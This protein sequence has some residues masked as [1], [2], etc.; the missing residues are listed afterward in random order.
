MSLHD[1]SQGFPSQTAI[2]GLYWDEEYVDPAFMRSLPPSLWDE[3]ALAHIE[4][5]LAVE[6]KASTSYE[7]F[8][9][10][11]D[12]AVKY[13]AG[14]IAEDEHRHHRVLAKIAAVL[15]A[16]VSDVATPVQHVEISAEKRKEMLNEARRLLEIEKADS[17][18]SERASP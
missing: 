3:R 8:A 17:D 5:H 18:C 10:A 16:E 11:E 6:A 14:L 15:R 9:N 13:L 7:A 4:R 12:P 2:P 1:N